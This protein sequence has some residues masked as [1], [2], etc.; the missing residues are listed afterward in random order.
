MKR[1]R[2]NRRKKQPFICL[3]WLFGRAPAT[4]IPAIPSALLF[5]SELCGKNAQAVSILPF[6]L[7]SNK[8]IA[9]K[10]ARKCLTPRL[11]THKTITAW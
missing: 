6:R 9:F 1:L 11:G 4:V 10:P 8:K 2:G 7:S 5:V 3:F